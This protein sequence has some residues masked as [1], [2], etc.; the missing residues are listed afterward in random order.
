MR[1]LL[2]IISSIVTRG[3]SWE[4]A[5]ISKKQRAMPKDDDMG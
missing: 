4:V 3:G 2:K 5:A 1:N